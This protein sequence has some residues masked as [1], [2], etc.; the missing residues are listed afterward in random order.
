[1]TARWKTSRGRGLSVFHRRSRCPQRFRHHYRCHCRLDRRQRQR[2]H[3]LHL[4][5]TDPCPSR[6]CWC[7]RQVPIRCRGRCCCLAPDRCHSPVRC[8]CPAR[9]HCHCH[10]RR[11]LP[12]RGCRRSRLQCRRCCCWP[13]HCHQQSFRRWKRQT[14]HLLERLQQGLRLRIFR[15]RY[16]NPSSRL[17]LPWRCRRRSH[18]CPSWNL[19]SQ[20]NL[21][22]IALTCRLRRSSRQSRR[23]DPGT[24]LREPRWIRSSRL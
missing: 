16:W 11:N 10:C 18:S 21:P 20:E 1:M 6:R 8:H 5:S 14:M 22:R 19:K 17:R 15:P 4:D 12:T 13:G 2:C 3:C 7:C 9:H 24:M 23:D